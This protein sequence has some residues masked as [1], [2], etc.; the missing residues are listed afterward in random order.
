MLPFPAF[1]SQDAFS[2]PLQLE[3]TPH[4]GPPGLVA[5]NISLALISFFVSLL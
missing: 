2:K 5:H 3:R 4:S 1:L